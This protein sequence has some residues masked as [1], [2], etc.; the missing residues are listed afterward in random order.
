MHASRAHLAEAPS[1][2]HIRIH[3]LPAALDG[4]MD[5]PPP[6]S[7]NELD[8]FLEA[9][10]GHSE[11]ETNKYSSKQNPGRGHDRRAGRGTGTG[12][13]APDMQPDSEQG[14]G[15]DGDASE[16]YSDD[17]FEAEADA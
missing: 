1:G 17:G 14:G 13:S 9:A 16:G 12:V 10:N 3:L 15:G 11:P 4:T 8:R 7:S 2:E 5:P 6:L